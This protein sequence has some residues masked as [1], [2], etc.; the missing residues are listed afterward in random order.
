MEIID[1]TSSD[2]SEHEDKE[3]QSASSSVPTSQQIRSIGRS[4]REFVANKRKV[5]LP[6]SLIPLKIKPELKNADVNVK[7][8]KEKPAV[9]LKDDQNTYHNANPYYSNIIKVMVF[10]CLTDEYEGSLIRSTQKQKLEFFTNASGDAQKLSIRL[11]LRKHIWLR[12]SALKYP[13][14]GDQVG[15]LIAELAVRNVIVR[16]S[17]CDMEIEELVDLLKAPE[18]S[19]IA[20]KLKIPKKTAGNMKEDL[21]KLSNQKCVF[22]AKSLL[23]E[24]IRNLSSVYIKDCFRLSHWFID[25]LNTVIFVYTMFT[26]N[27]IGS[28]LFGASDIVYR[29]LNTNKNPLITVNRDI[30]LF[31]FEEAFQ[32]YMH[33]STVINDLD[34]LM[35][36]EKDFS[37]CLCVIKSAINKYNKFLESKG[38]VE[39]SEPE[40][41]KYLRRYQC[42]SLV[43]RLKYLEVECHCKLKGYA[44]S[45]RLI[46]EIIA[47][48]KLSRRKLGEQYDRLALIYDAHLFDRNKCVLTIEAALKAD[49]LPFSQLAL[50]ERAHKLLKKGAKKEGTKSKAAEKENLVDLTAEKQKTLCWECSRIN[51]KC[52][53][54]LGKF[55]MVKI[56]EL[57]IFARSSPHVRRE[58]RARF[59]YGSRDGSTTLCTVEEYVLE[60]AKDNFNLKYGV[61]REGL[62]FETLFFAVMADIVFSSA[63]SNVYFSE[64]QS[65]PLDWMSSEFY[66]NRK[67][68]IDERFEE[69]E[70]RDRMKELVKSN[71]E[72]FP[73]CVNLDAHEKGIEEVIELLNSFEPSQLCAIFNKILSDCSISGVPD[74]TLWGS[75]GESTETNGPGKKLILLEVKGPGDHLSYK[76]IVWLHFFKSIDVDARVARVTTTQNELD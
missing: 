72:A 17:V 18:L 41:P 46:E 31:E 74:L 38:N 64:Y 56:L 12:E 33:L 14:F 70:S 1:I 24:K 3:E 52:C 15:V 45:A 25:A 36:V 4:R 65:R 16:P 10:H 53:E 2:D 48:K 40:I 43:Q 21:I 11:F 39:N 55:S 22:S 69:L 28:D 67:Y 13:E 34:N 49:V 20:S 62:L 35:V 30:K 59:I 47:S 58:Q 54:I 29:I 66:D 73:D 6:E 9:I 68:L 51:E 26:P 32:M 5:V 42:G 76:Q 57:K 7:L 44:V 63:V 50:A 75:R 60:Y 37:K 27:L 19:S 23:K 71:L 8:E 61:H